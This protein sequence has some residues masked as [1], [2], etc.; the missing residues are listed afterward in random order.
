MPYLESQ[1]RPF[2]DQLVREMNEY[3]ITA[4]GDLNYVLFAFCRRY[5]KSYCQMKNFMAELRECEAEIRRRLFI[6]HEDKK[7]EENGDVY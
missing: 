3:N 1:A 4:N 2:L 6:P 7:L 5:F